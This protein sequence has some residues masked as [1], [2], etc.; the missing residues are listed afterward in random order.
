MTTFRERK[1][2]LAL[3]VLP[4]PFVSLL[5]NC[6]LPIA[7]FAKGVA[8]AQES[9]APGGEGN[10]WDWDSPNPGPGALDL[11]AG[12]DRPH[13]STWW[14]LFQLLAPRILFR[15]IWS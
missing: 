5:L 7:A 4:V 8:V 6:A 15:W 1:H 10:P 14:N 3:F 12:S 2:W 11:G 13:R 9:D